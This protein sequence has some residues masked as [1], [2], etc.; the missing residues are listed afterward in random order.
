M[1]I[2]PAS[3]YIFFSVEEKKEDKGGIILSDV[4]PARQPIGLV[5]A[6]GPEVKNIKVGDKIIFNAFIVKDI[7][8]SG[9]KF[10]ILREKDIYGCL[11]K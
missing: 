9:K 3:D 11:K 6:V 8:V 1:K 2:Q 4:S 7:E 5:E 10:Q